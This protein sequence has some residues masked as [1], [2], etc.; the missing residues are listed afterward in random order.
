MGPVTVGCR[1]RN[2]AMRQRSVRVAKTLIDPAV[3]A[4]R[5]RRRRLKPAGTQP[6]KRRRFRGANGQNAYREDER[7]SKRPQT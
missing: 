4:L 6:E 5:L 1:R 3:T 2:P 7:R